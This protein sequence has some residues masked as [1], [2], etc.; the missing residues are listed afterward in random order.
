ME[1][2]GATRR[3][4]GWPEAGAAI[5]G[6]TLLAVGA[7]L[8]WFTLFA[9]L[10][11]YP[12]IISISGRALAVGGAVGIVAGASLLWAPPRRAAVVR[13]G[14]AVIGALLLGYAAYLVVGLLATMRGLAAQPLAVPRLGPGLFVSTTGAALVAVAPW[15][16]RSARA[17]G[18]ARLSARRPDAGGPAASAPRAPSTTPGPAAC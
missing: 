13:W 5:V 4:H 15:L 9:G 2:H 7:V 6:G 3:T 11:R 10:H 14:L 12:G 17:P 8:P 18:T 16:R 1:G